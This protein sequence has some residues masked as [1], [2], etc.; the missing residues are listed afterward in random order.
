MAGST[1][2][3]HPEGPTRRTGG[4][5]FDGSPVRLRGR[6]IGMKSPRQP[7]R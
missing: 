3:R 1:F 5:E 4:T 6:S 7:H 2:A